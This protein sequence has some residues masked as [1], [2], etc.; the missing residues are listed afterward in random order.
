M[1][2]SIVKEEDCPYPGF[3]QVDLKEFGFSEDY[4]TSPN[5]GFADDEFTPV[6]VRQVDIGEEELVV[7]N[8]SG[9]YLDISQ[10]YLDVS[11][12]YS[13]L[14]IQDCIANISFDSFN[15]EEDPS[16]VMNDTDFDIVENEDFICLDF[17]RRNSS[18][19]MAD[20]TPKRTFAIKSSSPITDNSAIFKF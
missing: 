7:E 12:N 6:F 5:L 10:S 11:E 14:S 13:D 16:D 9:C 4:L 8:D 20:A 19:E 17:S 2:F 1:D 18:F 15:V 3:G